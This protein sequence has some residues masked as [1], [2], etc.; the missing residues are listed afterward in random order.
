MVLVLL[1][2]PATAQAHTQVEGVGDV[3]A[4]HIYVPPPSLASM[5]A[6]VTPDIEQLVQRLLAELTGMQKELRAGLS[7]ELAKMPDAK[8]AAAKSARKKSLSK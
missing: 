8:K 1:A 3:L 4:A 2:L 7:Y 6:E 5:V